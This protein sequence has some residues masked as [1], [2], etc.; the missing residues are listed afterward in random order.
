[1]TPTEKTQ[2]DTRD[3]ALRAAE[4]VLGDIAQRHRRLTAAFAEA[5]HELYLVGG[6][7]RDALLGRVSADLDFTTSA[8][9]EI[10]QPILEQYGDVVWTAGI[11]FGTVSCE[12]DHEQL[13]ITTFRADAYDRVSR[14]PVVRFGESLE[15]DLVR[16][17]FRVNAIA[18]RMFDDGHVEIHDPLG[19]LG[20]LVAGVIDTPGAPEDSFNDDPLRMLRAARFVS[21]LGFT[22][23]DRVKDAMSAMAEQLDR[24]T[25]E[26]VQAEFTK[27]ML[28]TT[29]WEGVDILVDTG[30]CERFLPEIPALKLAP[31]EHLQHKDV[32]AH[33][34]TV[35]RQACDLEDNGPDLILR[36]G[37][38]LHDIGKPDTRA[39]KPGGGVTFHQHEVVGA[40]LVR[41]RLKALK[42]PKD[43]INAVNNLVFLHMRFYGYS[44]QAWTDSAVRRYVNDAGD[45]LDRLNKIV[46]ADCTT[47]NKKK[48]ARLSRAY[49]NLEQRIAELAEQEDLAKVRPDLDGG[50]IMRILGIAPGP[51][52]GK[53]W[54]FLKELRLERGPLGVE[55]AEKELLAW[56]EENKPEA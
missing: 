46:R 14:N 19:G 47:R 35:L 55:E 31:D 43:V 25:V 15:D 36:L 40:K 49:D 23:A 38:L 26:R 28:G 29:P 11:E 48:S 52:V 2:P 30:L 27:L 39:A 12:K 22:I 7:V 44:D 1:M 32:Y 20:D 41:H 17:D 4:K 51:T 54:S 3:D 42:Y 24:I 6:P 9:P 16:R 18:A 34:L 50:D 5:G 13:E 53:A 10:I 8:T 21:Q 45:L 37:A 56:W 33:S